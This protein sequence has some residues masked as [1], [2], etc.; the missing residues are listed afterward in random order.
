[1]SSTHATVHVD[2]VV[3]VDPL[4]VWHDDGTFSIR[5]QAATGADGVDVWIHGTPDQFEKFV[6][7]LD[8]E[9]HAAINRREDAIRDALIAG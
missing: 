4:V 1:M 6:I 8:V 9:T 2:A 5:I 7:D 3:D